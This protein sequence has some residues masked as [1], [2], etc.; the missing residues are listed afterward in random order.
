M[1]TIIGVAV[2]AAVTGYL[3]YRY[4]AGKERAL[5]YRLEQMLADAQKGSF[6]IRDICETELSAMENGFQHFLEDRCRAEEVQKQ[7]KNLVQELISDIAHQTLTP[8]SNLKIYSELLKEAD[9]GHA[10]L[11]D[12]IVQQTDQLDFLI[13]SLV[14]LSR[15]EQGMIRVY[16]V[17]SSVAELLDG[18]RRDYGPKAE[19]KGIC[20]NVA[21]TTV[22]AVFDQK[23]TAEAVGNLVDNAVKY[24]GEG[25]QVEI[26]VE[27][28]SFFVR[29]DVR[30]NGMGISEGEIPKIFGRFY[31][32]M[33]A[34]DYPGAGIG[35]FLA[36]E[37]IQAQ[38]GYIRVTSRYGK[39]SVFS[40]FLPA[41]PIVSK[42]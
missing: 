12:T 23:W 8:V 15:M 25:G 10:Q 13:Q 39:G 17:L 33:D 32:S 18:I 2:S 7:Q 36:R 1:G 34:R 3:W 26:R 20:L 21:R 42:S 24:T 37:M 31:R 16:P 38:K 19:A 5:L 41:P 4:F 9:T 11:V 29:M 27:P 22:Q 30:D 6:C 28:Y 14:K 35:L 40:V